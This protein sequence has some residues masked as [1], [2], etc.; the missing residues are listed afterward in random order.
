MNKLPAEVNFYLDKYSD[1]HW[2]LELNHQRLF[3]QIVVVPCLAEYQNVITLLKSI[4]E[5]Q[6]SILS[7]TLIMFVINNSR[8]A[9]GE[10]KTDNLKTFDYLK[11]KYFREE[12]KINIGIVDAFTNEKSL[13]EKD[14]GVGLARKIGMDL[15]LKYFNY[16]NKRKNILICLDADCVVDKN[17]LSEIS[18]K[19]NKR[20]MFAAYVNFKHR[21]SER[22]QI[23]RAII[24][25]EIFLRYYVLGLQYANSPFAFHSI[26]STM[27]CEYSAYIKVQG[28]NKKKAAEDFYFLEKLAKIYTID[29]INDT[30]VYPA[31]RQSYR[32]PF[33]TGQRVNRF[34]SGTH[35]EYELYSPQIFDVLKQWNGIYLNSELSESKIILNKAREINCVLYDFLV[36][37][38]FEVA[39]GKIIANS[40]SMTQ[41]QNQ[42][43][44][45]F[46]GFSTLKLVH[47]LRDKEF[48]NEFMFDA[49]N[50]MFEKIGI[51]MSIRETNSI[52][53]EIEDQQQYLNLLRIYA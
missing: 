29:K 7:E 27:V 30:T 42:K 33:G 38:K 23:N 6:E 21:F 16:S 40:K 46:D 26:G 28:M 5:N 44:M 20:N 34:L 17:Y 4:S 37:K 51:T 52:L 49:L 1:S 48:P 53:S 43:K 47:L 13:I 19:F 18:V 32:V 31:A 12:M 9:S 15:A 25:Y 24:A 41:L 35:N 39:F 11:Q 10:I 2:N 14:A 8:T 22:E 45:W 50:S 36:E 3:K